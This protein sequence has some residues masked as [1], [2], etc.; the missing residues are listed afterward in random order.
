M[1]PARSE[2]LAKLVGTRVHGGGT[3]IFDDEWRERGEN[4]EIDCERRKGRVKNIVINNV[5]MK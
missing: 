2:D 4:D 1:I 3:Y 5:S